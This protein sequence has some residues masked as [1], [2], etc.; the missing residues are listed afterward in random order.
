MQIGSE[1]RLAASCL[2]RDQ[3]YF[4]HESSCFLL[5]HFAPL[6]LRTYLPIQINEELRGGAGLPPPVPQALLRPDHARP[7]PSDEGAAKRA[8][9]KLQEDQ[10]QLVQRACGVCLMGY[11]KQSSVVIVC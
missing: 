10:T 5:D 1:P 6:S 7:A 11:L 3:C 2:G 9:G 4:S 8:G